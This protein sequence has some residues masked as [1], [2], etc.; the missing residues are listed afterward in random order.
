MHKCTK[1][2]TEFE[3]K[4]CPE[5]GAKWVEP[6]DPNAAHKCQKCGVVFKGKFCPECGAKWVEPV[7]PNAAHTCQ[8]CGVVFKGKFCPECGTKFHETSSQDVVKTPK[9]GEVNETSE[10]EETSS[11]VSEKSAEVRKVGLLK[12]QKPASLSVAYWNI[13]ITE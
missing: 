13:S 7:D 9:M 11:S 3:G 8:K 6:V 4:F 5:C 2:G 1:C 10:V 12:S